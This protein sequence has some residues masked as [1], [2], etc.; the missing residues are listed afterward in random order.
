[1][2]PARASHTRRSETSRR[3]GRA[4]RR[5]HRGP[6]E[7]LA[8][9]FTGGVL[10]TPSIATPVPSAAPS[11]PGDYAYGQGHVLET[12]FVISSSAGPNGESLTGT[13]TTTGYLNW[14]ATLEPSSRLRVSESG[15]LRPLSGS[16]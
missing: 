7:A 16:P 10:V 4:A 12:D 13:L 9:V 8:L 1:M 14:M 3:A 6:Q 11:P 15:Y 2:R 5:S